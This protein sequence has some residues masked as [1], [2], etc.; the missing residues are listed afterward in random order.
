M[1]EPDNPSASVEVPA[2]RLLEQTQQML[3][4]L[5][6]AISALAASHQAQTRLVAQMAGGA[7]GGEPSGGTAEGDLGQG[8]S[9]FILAL[10][11]NAYAREVESM[12]PWV[13]EIFLKIYGRE[14]SGARPWCVRWPEHPEVV[15]RLHALWLAW[16]ALTHVE[17][18]HAGPSTWQR[19]H[20]DPALM[21][22]RD[23][24]GPLGACTTHPDRPTHRLLPVPDLTDL[25]ALPRPQPRPRPQPTLPP[26]PD[27]DLDSAA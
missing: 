12:T 13:D 5:P 2:L 10:D 18:G 24:A 21:Q 16:Q 22:L 25:A 14:V 17:A 3:A 19:D 27:P 9:M 15:A 6:P 4:Q 11:D 23:P 1:P 8:E 26:Q 20:L 7:P